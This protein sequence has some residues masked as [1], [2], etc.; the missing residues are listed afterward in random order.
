MDNPKTPAVLHP[1][2]YEAIEAA[3]METEKGRWFLAEYA[4]RNRAA[5]TLTVLDAVAGLER[6]LRRERR[7]DID[8]IRLD[9]GEM[10]DAIDRTKSE[11]A[12]LKHDR[13]ELSRVERATSELDSIVTQTEAATS[14]ILGAAEKLQEI[15]FVLREAGVEP[16]ACDAIEQLIMQIYTA[17]SFQDLTGQRTQKVVHVLRFLES[18][19]NSMMDIWGI[20]E[21]PGRQT[22][23]MPVRVDERPDAH[24]LNG[25]A[26]AGEGI[27]QSRIDD[28]LS[29]D[30]ADV[31]WD[32]DA[33]EAGQDLS[34]DL[35]DGER[36]PD[37]D[38]GDVEAGD[39]GTTAAGEEQDPGDPDLGSEVLAHDHDD[40]MALDRM[41]AADLGRDWV[42]EFGDEALAAQ[43][44][45]E[46]S[47]AGVD[48]EVDGDLFAADP[49][50][51]SVEAALAQATAAVDEAIET[52]KDVSGAVSA[53][54]GAARR[55]G[56][57][58]ALG[59]LGRTERQALFS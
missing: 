20:G 28:L 26:L 40:V 48:D 33:V 11:I 5:D 10:K 13:G 15:A 8:R 24:L 32:T 44:A 34:A 36:T 17:C 27:D 49:D 25:P 12:Q 54:G 35:A 53:G 56:D 31:E 7:P 16:E 59:R 38:A 52:L 51:Q 3:V 9:V 4:R 22:E 45:A 42:T 6:L 29:F 2:D 1:G 37:P 21:E 58:D 50:E 23:A 46:M 18:R 43:L 55:S 47:A 57:D 19:I 30:A 41:V 14:E 39:D